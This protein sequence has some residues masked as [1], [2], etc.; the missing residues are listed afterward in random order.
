M[1][2]EF[3][4]AGAPASAAAPPDAPTL[5][6]TIIDT[7]SGS[8]ADPQNLGTSGLAAGE[9]IVSMFGWSSNLALSSVSGSDDTSTSLEPRE[10]NDGPLDE[11]IINVAGAGLDDPIV[12]NFDGSTRRAVGVLA[13]VDGADTA[14]AATRAQDANAGAPISPSVVITGGPR[15]LLVLRT[16]NS[17]G[18]SNIGDPVAPTGHNLE[19]QG[20]NG[21]GSTSTS[22]NTAG[23]ASITYAVDDLTWVSGEAT[24][25]AATWQGMGSIDTQP[26]QAGTIVLYLDTP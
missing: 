6:G 26:W 17:R 23:M 3:L 16:V 7:F 22:L 12:Y 20:S 19:R 18:G 4:L 15:N 10:S 13:A 24:V 21:A 14:V 5:A 8:P 9:M 2:F 1:S 11:R 25:P